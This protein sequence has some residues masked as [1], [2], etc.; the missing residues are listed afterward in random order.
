M[1]YAEFVESRRAYIG[2][3]DAPVIMGVSPFKTLYELWQDKLNLRKDEDSFVKQKG[4]EMEPEAREAYIAFTG[5]YV[6]PAL[7]EHPTIFYM[8]AN[9]DGLS[10]C[11]KIAVEIKCP[12]EKDHEVAKQ[13]LVPE[14][15]YPQLQHQLAVTGLDVIDYFSYRDGSFELIQVKRDESY[16]KRLY[17]E[18]RKFWDCVENLTPPAL[19]ERDYIERDDRA[20][21]EAARRWVEALERLKEAQ[22]AEEAA[23]EELIYLSDGQTSLG[24]GVRLQKIIRKGN[25]DYSKI[26]SLNDVD[27]E[28]YRKPPTESWRLSAM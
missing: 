2:A 15:Y 9:L 28:K 11:G 25:V 12:G 19:S 20:W 18:C 10:S 26:E 27:L 23:K 6:E 8:A 13:G 7:V 22:Q 14:K 17:V 24:A 21:K 1:E 5:N 4:R 3:S 16:I